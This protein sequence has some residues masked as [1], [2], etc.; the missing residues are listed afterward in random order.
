MI[1]C[2][3]VLGSDLRRSLRTR[4]DRRGPRVFLGV[5]ILRQLES[6]KLAQ[7]HLQENRKKWSPCGLRPIPQQD[8]CVHAVRRARS[9]TSRFQLSASFVAVPRAAMTRIQDMEQA[10]LH[11]YAAQRM[12]RALRRARQQTSANRYQAAL[13]VGEQVLRAAINAGHPID[14]PRALAQLMLDAAIQGYNVSSDS[15]SPP[16]YDSGSGKDDADPPPPPYQQAP[17]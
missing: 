9:K 6:N 5:I 3:H 12:M 7:Q 13:R 11:A 8:L 16:E 4:P 15:P 2:R 17:T 1:Y 10:Q 14:N